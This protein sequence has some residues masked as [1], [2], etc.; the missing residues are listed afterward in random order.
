MALLYWLRAPRWQLQRQTPNAERHAV[1]QLGASLETPYSCDQYSLPLAS[2]IAPRAG[3]RARRRAR[4]RRRLRASVLTV[5]A[6]D[7]GARLPTTS[8][9]RLRPPSVAPL[10]PACSDPRRDRPALTERQAARA[11]AVQRFGRCA[12]RLRRA[13]GATIHRYHVNDIL[14]DPVSFAIA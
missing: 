12:R 7:P 2:G 5:R 11:L 3:G 8:F 13:P 10:D 14:V 1:G 9:R 4:A 6:S